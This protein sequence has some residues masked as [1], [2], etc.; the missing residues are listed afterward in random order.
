MTNAPEETAQM[1][2]PEGNSQEWAIKNLQN[3]AWEKAMLRCQL[4]TEPLDI[5][6]SLSPLDQEIRRLHCENAHL[7]A[8]NVGWGLPVFL[9]C[10]CAALLIRIALHTTGIWSFDQ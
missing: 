2:M 4:F 10:V 1:P 9:T 8:R 5:G 6:E 3:R 7:R